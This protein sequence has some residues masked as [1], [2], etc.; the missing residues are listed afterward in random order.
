MPHFVTIWSPVPK[1]RGC[2]QG[3]PEE[4]FDCIAAVDIGVIERRDA[5]VERLFD[6]ALNSRLI[7][8]PS[9]QPPDACDYR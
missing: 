7:E 2:F 1:S 6:P 3:L 5:Q 4:S 9:V 8:S